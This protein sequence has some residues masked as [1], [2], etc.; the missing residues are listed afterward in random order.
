M[1]RRRTW[2]PVPRMPWRAVLLLGL[3]CVVVGGFLMVR[4]F[5]SLVVLAALVVLGLVLTGVGDS[6][7]AEAAARP[8]LARL[9]GAGAIIA[10]MVAVGW[11]GVTIQVLAIVI[12]IALVVSGA[13]KLVAALFGA[14]SERV[15]L[16]F[17][18]AANLIF[19]VLALTLPAATL[20]VLAVVFGLYLVFFGL[21][22]IVQAFA[23]RRTLPGAG[24]TER[25]TW[26]YLLRL[27]G[28]VAA[29]MLAI[30][31]AALAIGVRRAQPST[32]GMFYTAPAPLPAG[33]A[34]TVIR[35]E[36][37]DGFFAGATAYRVLYLSTSYDRTPTA[38]SGIIIVPN[39]P[40]PSGGRKV[41][42]WTHGTTGVAPNCAPSLIAGADY[43]PALP[44]LAAFMEAGYVVAAT[45]YQGL[46]TSG[47]HPYLVGDSE[48]MNALDSVRAAQHLPEASA[49]TDFVVWG[50]SQG[51]HAALFTGQLASTYAPELH[52]RGVV[53]S[54]PAA[55]LINLFQTKAAASDAIGNLLISMTIISW[56]QVYH[57]ASLA[58][59]VLPAARP[60]ARSIAENCIQNPEQ[61]QASLPAALLLNLRFFSTPP[62]EAEPWK[63]LLAENI[64]GHLRTN[65]PILIG[66]GANDPI[67]SPAVQAQFVKKL[68]AAGDAV[69]YRL[70]PGL[71]HLTIA[72]DTW[73]AMVQ[74][75]ADRF[76][77]RPAS[78]TCGNGGKPTA[79][80]THDAVLK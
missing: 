4:P 58:Q 61:I 33:P 20:L 55:D 34:G 77:D 65:A 64:P 73:P 80:S 42:A 30:S 52:L 57:D 53:A 71:G 68:C 40:A 46:G 7:S 31:G 39:T 36:V 72:H 27:V 17:G 24:G 11:P 54:A 37:M 70:Y 1:L 2:P 60:L 76:A 49:S 16:A 75:I 56:A 10:G 67:V 69:E 13:A 41:V 18:G 25:P 19:G 26:P 78:T 79:D 8:W 32:P 51:G 48:G 9:V 38:V 6:V 3:A 23:L 21:R 5:T 28:A 66:Q 35:S 45:D 74:W 63:T 47:P 15:L 43:A 14:G 59:I 50:E 22:Q 29:L 44:G 62:V 12:G